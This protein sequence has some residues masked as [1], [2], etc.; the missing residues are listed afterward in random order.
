MHRSSVILWAQLLSD[1]GRNSISSPYSSCSII[2]RLVHIC[3]SRAC[4]VSATIKLFCL[5]LCECPVYLMAVGT[6]VPCCA[7]RQTDKLQ[8]SVLTFNHCTASHNSYQSGPRS[9]WVSVLCF[10]PF[11]PQEC[12]EF[13]CMHAT[14]PNFLVSKL[15]SKG[16]YTK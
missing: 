10:P 16:L 9:F 11:L 3:A 6:H 5:L 4:D 7:C 1:A 13:R 14:S 15:R 8:L 2:Q 12:F